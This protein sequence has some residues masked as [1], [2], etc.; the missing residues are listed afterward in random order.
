M[1]KSE[2]AIEKCLF[3]LY[4]IINKKVVG[5]VLKMGSPVL[6]LVIPC[7]NEEAVLPLTIPLFDAVMRDL[8]AREAISADSKILFVND[9]STDGTWQL[10]IAD[11]GGHF[12]IQKWQRVI[13]GRIDPVEGKDEGYGLYNVEKRLCLF[14]NLDHAMELDTSQD[15]LSIIIIPLSR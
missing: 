4:N 15:G 14:F 8:I 7:Y 3:L 1:R 10:C 12:T 11:T 13:S 5:S 2:N 6:F 9:G